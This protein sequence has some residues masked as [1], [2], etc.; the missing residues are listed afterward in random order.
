MGYSEE[1]EAHDKVLNLIV[2]KTGLERERDEF[3]RKYPNADPSGLLEALADV[4]EQIKKA[5]QKAKN[6]GT[7]R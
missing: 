1:A 2:R 5:R 6:F 7:G 4:D 3:K